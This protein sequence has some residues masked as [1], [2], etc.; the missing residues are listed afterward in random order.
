M[1]SPAK[2]EH[3]PQLVVV[4]TLNVDLVCRLPSLPRPG[5]T[6]LASSIHHEFGGKG[7]NQAVAASRQGAQVVVI[8]AVGDDAH[9]TAY[10]DHLRQQNLDVSHIAR[11]ADLPTGTAH[12]YLDATGENSIIVNP[13][14]NQRLDAA[15]VQRAFESLPQTP[16]IV[17]MQLES[18]LPAVMEALRIA[19]DQNIRSVLNASPVNHNFAWGV[20]AI[21]TVIV[22]EHECIEWFGETAGS[23]W[24]LPSANVDKILSK[25]LIQNL[26]ITRGSRSTLHLAA[27]GSR[28]TAPAHPVSPV[29]TVGAG[30]TF[31]GTLAASLGATTHDDWPDALRRANTA[32][33]LATLSL[34]AQT[35]MP[36][37]SVVDAALA[38]ID[39]TNALPLA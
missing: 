34:G 29:D 24:E 37:R 38:T 33:A 30:D 8:G 31:A 25:R 35:A 21:D 22:N 28:H 39:N 3:R 13:G 15:L 26:V 11:V 1:S 12:V 16:E 9:G 2:S 32:A 18:P 20:H 6:V 17:M 5:E 7:A 10:L 4:G 19:A 27:N 23:L 14:S 36:T